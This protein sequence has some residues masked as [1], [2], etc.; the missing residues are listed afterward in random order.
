MSNQENL[1]IAEK[2]KR[3]DQERREQN[4]FSIM[5]TILLVTVIGMI[6]FVVN[7]NQP[8]ASQEIEIVEISRNAPTIPKTVRLSAGAAEVF[9]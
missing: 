6:G 1:Q 9:E 8:V 2:L 7:H 3:E 4:R 5:I